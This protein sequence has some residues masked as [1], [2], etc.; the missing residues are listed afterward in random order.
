VHTFLFQT[1]Q[2]LKVFPNLCR[3]GYLRKI[4]E[5]EEL[6]MKLKVLLFTL[7]LV[8]AFSAGAFAASGIN[9]VVNGEAV[10]DV[11]AKVIDGSTYVPLRAVSEMLGADVSYD[12]KTKTAYVNLGQSANVDTSVDTSVE[13]ETETEVTTG[14]TNVIAGLS[15]SEVEATIKSDAEADW[16]GD[17]Q[18]QAYQIKTQTEAYEAL[19]ALEIDSQVKEDILN[20]AHV[21]WG[22]DFQMVLYEYETQLEAYQDLNN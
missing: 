14:F 13:V 16:D 9:L 18:M 8:L 5:G 21:N 11:D 1:V 6:L 12:A 7:A 3:K 4:F 19:I 22:F 2:I 10:T 15:A 20:K 17:F